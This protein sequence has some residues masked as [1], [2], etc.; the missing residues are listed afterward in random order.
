MLP[1]SFVLQILRL[2]L[3]ILSLA[4][5]VLLA[6][7]LVVDGQVR[8]LLVVVL[9]PLG[10]LRIVESLVQ[11]GEIQFYAIVLRRDRSVLVAVVEKIDDVG[12]IE[13]S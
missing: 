8:G 13:L 2:V 6:P 3:R 5:L 4:R 11:I 10:L 12:L 1:V 7:L 9:D